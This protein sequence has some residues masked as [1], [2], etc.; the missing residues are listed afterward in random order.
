MGVK[1]YVSGVMYFHASLA[2]FMQGVSF[3]WGVDSPLGF[4]LLCPALGLGEV[5]QVALHVQALCLMKLVLEG[6]AHFLLPTISVWARDLSYA[7]YSCVLYWSFF[8]PQFSFRRLRLVLT[9]PFAL[10]PFMAYALST[11][12]LF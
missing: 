8:S 11:S 7:L 10:F 6:T 1:G 3:Q 12:L 2:C 9:F 4:P 5:P